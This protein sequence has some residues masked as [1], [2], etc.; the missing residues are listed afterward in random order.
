MKKMMM[1]IMITA[2]LCSV[3]IMDAEDKEAP[4]KKKKVHYIDSPE[5][6]KRI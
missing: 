3:T 5:R 2:A 1:L 6:Q 4:K